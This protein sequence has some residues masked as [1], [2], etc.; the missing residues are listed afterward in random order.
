M[1]KG[2]VLV[3]VAVL[4]IMFVT[5][6][7]TSNG[8]VVGH[9]L[10]KWRYRF[11][12]GIG[13]IFGKN[14]VEILV[15]KENAEKHS[16]RIWP[17]GDSITEGMDGNYSYRSNLNQLFKEHNVEVTFV[18]TK[19]GGFEGNQFG[20][21]DRHDGYSGYRAEDVAYLVKKEIHKVEFDVA[22]IHLGTN[23]LAYGESPK[24]I[25]SDINGLIETLRERNPKVQ[26]VLAE[27]IPAAYSVDPFIGLNKELRLFA[28]KVSTE[29]SP[30]IIVDQF[31][32]LIHI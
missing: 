30:V 2:F 21:N 12:A 8:S 18:G 14:K 3:G 4:G 7:S 13:E 29:L 5:T 26:I 11:E 32:S 1:H 16:L 10:R 27:V 22:L 31:L 20:P 25:A 23:D 28:E 19:S 6:S 9:M 15:Q 17:I 24:E